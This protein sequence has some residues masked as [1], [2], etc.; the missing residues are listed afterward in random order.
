M[1]MRTVLV[2]V[3]ASLILTYALLAQ[4]QRGGGPMTMPPVPGS[5]P[6]RN[7]VKVAEGVYLATGTGSMTTVSNAVVVVNDEDV[8]IVDPGVTPAAATALVADVKTLT[9]KPVKYA[10]DTHYHYDHAFGNQVFGPD[11]TLIGHENTRRRLMGPS[12][13]K[14]R[15]YL[16]NSTASIANRFKTLKQQIA[17]ATDPQQRA[18]LERQLAIHQLY[19]DEQPKITPTPPDTTLSRDMTLHRGSREIQ[20]RFL[21]RAHTDGDVVVFLPK[22]RMIATG[23]MITG[24]LSY[25]GDAFMREWPATLEQVLTLD[26]DT[27]LPGHGAAFKGKDHIRNLQ[28]YWRDFYDQAIALRKQG[29]SPEEAAKR[30]DLTKHAGAIPAVKTPGVDVRGVD[31][32]YD[33]ESNP[34]APVR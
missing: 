14:E 6:S 26:F 1:R 29:V 5:L 25:T 7:F 33:L 21:G 31:R 8:L 19:A 2:P 3:L 10:V 16:T 22:E 30:I 24:S 12:S 28:A 4:A 15:T 20:I 27:V 32:I 13:L 9:N 11:V 18:I 17:E 23:D 34:N